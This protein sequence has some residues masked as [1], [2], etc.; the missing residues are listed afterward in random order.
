MNRQAAGAIV[1][2]LA[3]AFWREPMPEEAQELYVEKIATLTDEALARAAVEEVIEH[4]DRLPSLAE[5][6]EA[7]HSQPRHFTE[8]LPTGPFVTREQMRNDIA[9]MRARRA[10]K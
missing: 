1:H 3:T 6:L 2:R 10:Q 5:I 8:F 7:Y 4:K 9:A